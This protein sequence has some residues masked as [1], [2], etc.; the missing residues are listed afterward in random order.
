MHFT[1]ILQVQAYNLNFWSCKKKEI[2]Q[3]LNWIS[4]DRT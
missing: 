4:N 3:F 1:F 2:S